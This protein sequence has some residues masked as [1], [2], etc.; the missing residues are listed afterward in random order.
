TKPE[1][2]STGRPRTE[3]PNAPAAGHGEQSLH[4]NVEVMRNIDLCVLD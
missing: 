1:N 3:Q 2:S 4:G